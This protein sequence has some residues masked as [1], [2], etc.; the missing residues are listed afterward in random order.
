MSTITHNVIKK[1]IY[2]FVHDKLQNF[3]NNIEHK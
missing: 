1:N 2:T 3:F